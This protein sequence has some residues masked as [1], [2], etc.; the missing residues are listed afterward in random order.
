M[1]IKYMMDLMQGGEEWHRV[2]TG[3]L[4][5]SQMKN[6]IT[7]STLKPVKGVIDGTSAF[8]HE[9][10][11]QR[12]SKIV[13]DEYQSFDMERGQVEEVYAKDLYSKNKAQIKDCGFV[14][15]NNHGFIIGFS[16]DGLVGDDGQV[17]VK[18][19]KQKYQIQ[20]IIANAMPDEFKI[21]VQTGL[22]VTERKWCEFISYSNGLPMFTKAIEPESEVREAIIY[23]ASVFEKKA[24]ELFEIYMENSAGLI[25]AERRN[26]EDGTM[27]KPSDT[28]SET[29]NYYMAG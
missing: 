16:P 14:T 17:E 5:A 22:I 7:P 26:Y 3:I 18:S 15:N 4:T 25:V 21:Q 8:L 28:D 11:A 6:I 27:I 2:R 20:T 24:E 29:T 12:V 23:A 19:R 10:V 9:I 13:E 1:A